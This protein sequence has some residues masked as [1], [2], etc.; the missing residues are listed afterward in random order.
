MPL[1]TPAQVQQQVQQL[2]SERRRERERRERW[3]AERRAAA[4]ERR[5]RDEARSYDRLARVGSQM[6]AVDTLLR[7]GTG[8][9]GR[10]VTNAAIGGLMQIGLQRQQMRASRNGS[11]F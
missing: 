4:E 9:Q 1:L 7:G 10:A 5:L 8:A 6:S 11:R 2:E 3:E